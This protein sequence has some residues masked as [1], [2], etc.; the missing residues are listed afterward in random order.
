MATATNTTALAPLLPHGELQS[1]FDNIWFIQGQVK[2]PMKL[3]AKISRSMTIYKNPVSGELTL[4]N[5]MRL[6][7]EGL[8]QLQKLG[9]ITNVVRLGG[10]HGRDDLFYQRELNAKVFA[11]QGQA[12]SRAMEASDNP[13]D[14]YMRPD[15]WV[16]QASDLPIPNCELKIFSTSK[17]P[18]AALLI[19][20]HSG[21]LVT[22][23]SLQNTPKPDKFVNFPMKIMMKKFGFWVAYNVGPGWVQFAKPAI[24]DIRSVMELDFEHVLPGHGEAVIDNA[25]DKY[26]PIV[27]SD[28]KGCHE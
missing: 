6:S 15:A 17:P 25:K 7:P 23:D 11:I 26:R 8:D 9:P 14:S 5:S 10:F 21:V 13:D 16:S 28:I 18:E 3:P 19:N 24:G 27:E 4:I 20:E 12:Y 22:A 2:M 1:L